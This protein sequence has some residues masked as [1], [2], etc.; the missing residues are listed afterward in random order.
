MSASA[1]KGETDSF[2]TAT[3]HFRVAKMGM[4]GEDDSNFPAYTLRKRAE[5]TVYEPSY[6]SVLGYERFRGSSLAVPIHLEEIEEEQRALRAWLRLQRVRANVRRTLD[7]WPLALGLAL[8]LFSP[9]L[10]AMLLRRNPRMMSVVFPFVLL[11]GRPELHT[12]AH[13]A[14]TLPLLIQYA[15]FPLEGLLAQWALRKRVTVS[16]VAGC[17]AYLH[18]LGLI[19]LLMIGGVVWPA[20]TR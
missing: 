16:G 15:Q 14:A 10:R 3:E 17:I 7:L 8:G 11:A 2:S 5:H 13:W 4:S 6:T 1:K 12:G 9:H 20:L 19:Q 18:Y